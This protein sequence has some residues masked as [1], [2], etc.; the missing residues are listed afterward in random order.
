MKQEWLKGWFV[1]ALSSALLFGCVAD[2]SSSSDPDQGA[3]QDGGLITDSGPG[4]AGGEGGTGG[5]GGAGGAGGA[6][7]MGGE[8]GMGGMGGEGGMG[9]QG[10]VGGAP[11]AAC[12]DGVDND[13]D[14][15]TD[16]PDDPGCT[17]AADDDETDPAMA[18]QCAD[19]LDNDA[20][21]A[22]DL[23]DSDCVNSIDPTEDGQNPIAACSNRLDDDGDGATDFPLDPGC[24]AAGDDDETDPPAPRACANGADDDEDGLIDYPNDPGCQGRGDS[25]ETD[26]AVLPACGNGLDDDGDGAIDYPADEGCNSAADSAEVSSCAA[27]IEVIDLNAHLADN[28]AWEGSLEGGSALLQGSCGGSAGA[29]RVFAYRVTSALRRVTFRT[30]F[31]ETVVPTVV[32]V[33]S[34]CESADDLVC[35][36]GAGDV[37]GTVAGIDEPTQGLYFVVVDTGSRVVGPGPFRLVVEETP[38][39]HCRDGV[40]NDAD[41]LIDLADP[42]CIE[43]DDEDEADPEIVP[44]CADG[45]DNDQDGQADYPNDP[46]C[47]AAGV[48]RERPLCEL[49]FDSVVEVG[50]DGAQLVVEF[51]DAMSLAEPSCIFQLTGGEYVVQLTLDEPSD[52]ALDLQAD[53]GDVPVPVAMYVRADCANPDSEIACAGQPGTRQ[54]QGLEPGTYFIIV[55]ASGEV[56]AGAA[57][58]LSVAVSSL[59]R[60]CNDGDDNDADGLIDL[61]DPGCEQG[62]DN[63][64]SDPLTPPACAD[65]EDND[66]DGNIDWPADQECR[67][68][69][70]LDERL[71]CEA[72]DDVVAVGMDGGVFN[73]DTSGGVNN[74]SSTCAGSATSPEQA[75]ELTL[76]GPA[77][78][79]AEIIE[80]GYDTGLHMRTVCDAADSQVACDDD[81]G[82]GL[83]SRLSFNRLEAGRYFFFADGFG[84]NNSGPGTIEFTIEALEVAQCTDEADN[85]GDG[86]IDSADPG[87]ETPFDLD[88]TDP[89]EPPAC[90]DMLDNDEDGL[91]DFPNDPGCHAAGGLIETDYC[92]DAFPIIEVGQAGGDFAFRPSDGGNLTQGSCAVGDGLEQVLAI[93]LDDP[94]N[95]DISVATAGGA[96]A[97][98]V[99]YVR[100][101]CDDRASE[102][103]CN[104]GPA[105][106]RALDRGTWF[107]FIERERDEPA[108]A[109]DWVVTVAIESLITQC[110][111]E[112]D[113]DD[114]GLIDFADPGCFDARDTDETDPAVLPECG[115]GIDNDEDGATDY[116]DDADCRSA[117]GITEATRCDDIAA[118]EVNQA[119]GRF[120]VNP[121]RDPAGPY[122]ASC[123]NGD[124]ED[125]VFAV[126]IDEL[127]NLTVTS[128][129]ADGGRFTSILSARTACDDANAE[130]DCE[131]SFGG[132]LRL[133]ELEAGT[134]FILVERD[135]FS[136]DGAFEIDIAIESLIRECNDG[137]DND[138]D[139]LIDLDDPGCERGMDDDET[140]PAEVPECSDGIDND[141]DGDIDYPA[142][143]GCPAAGDNTE[144]LFCEGTDNV[145]EVDQAGG[146]FMVNTAG[147][148]DNYSGAAC[149]GGGR[150]EEQVFQLILD[151]PSAVTAEIVA[152][153]FDTMM[154]ARAGNCDV[155]D[156]L[157]CDDDGGAG[158]LSR[159]SFDQLEPGVYYFYT[160]AFSAGNAGAMS[161]QFTIVGLVTECNDGVDNDD[162]GLIDLADPGCDAGA[163]L[164]EADPVE[165][166]ACGD[167]ADN[168]GDGLID[169][170]EDTDCTAAGWPSEAPYCAGLPG[171]LPV[172]GADPLPLDP[173]EAG[174]D[175]YEGSCGNGAG[176]ESIA[177]LTLDVQS[178]VT[179]QVLG[180]DGAPDSAVVSV[181]SVCDAEGSEI[182]CKSSFSASLTEVME[183]GTYYVIVDTTAAIVDPV[184]LV[185][186]VRPLIVACND[187]VDNDD[188]GLIDLADP[189]CVFDLDADETDPADP[190][191]CADGIDNDE[192]GAIDYGEDPECYAAG[193]TSE[194]AACGAVEAVTL[195]EIG[196]DP[197][198]IDPNVAGGDAYEHS[199][200][201]GTNGEAVVGL[202][203][204]ER[205]RFTVSVID[206][207]GEPASAVV[208]VRQACDVAETELACKASFT[209]S[210]TVG[211]AE[212]GLYYI[213]IDADDLVPAGDLTV[214]IEVTSLIVACNDEIDNDEDGLIDLAD[215]GCAG[216]FGDSEIDPDVLPACAD[217]IDNDDDGQI[218]FPDD[219]ACIA[220]GWDF[221]QQLC[222][223]KPVAGALIDA[224]GQFALDTTGSE[225][226]YE[227]SCG[228]TSRSGDQVVFLQLTAPALVT[229][230]TT[231]STFDTT[232]Y[233]RSACDDAATEIAC[234]DDGGEGSQSLLS[235]QLE[236]GDYFIFVDG[237][238]AGNVGQTVLVVDVQPVPPPAP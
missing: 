156:F 203:L 210:L 23:A 8:G 89:A 73:Y 38:A 100:A 82:A 181:R 234:N 185:T 147:N 232:L 2:D 136:P 192:D 45:I 32:Y 87:C 206:V 67:A 208:S 153:D 155:G 119:G 194:L 60:Q 46:D 211:D 122:V 171:E 5:D 66:G 142:D 104:A 169:F 31:D 139:A 167:G 223:A 162:D 201:N 95:V 187:G 233:L 1:A 200:D 148:G 126:T 28:D 175:T 15:A 117:G 149:G 199:C 195:Y 80:A 186:T 90:L 61:A 59:V 123:D 235:Q 216:G 101:D 179:F 158:L 134:Y 18:N 237:Y 141:E 37:P 86:L 48:D 19:G 68:A 108:P 124:G 214:T 33:R 71:S 74:F 98:A 146:L 176:G 152:A 217:G 165:A 65:G 160:D 63:N 129:N 34:N 164:S 22:V 204:P 97:P 172:I 224:G 25:D 229:A 92:A 150:S 219:D 75:F 144:R 20:D 115:D 9:G 130:L 3:S 13:M 178:E 151:V 140:D 182:A 191:A 173:D 102:V 128:L 47:T 12:A 183:A 106:A 35:N 225:N 135:L 81:G 94:S 42:G 180:A 56:P 70:D 109:D 50:Q 30:D 190:P 105:R 110:N 51:P 4:G 188:D 168:D 184:D 227:A 62:M 231:Q 16:F 77:R 154:F 41:G 197:L 143:D 64:E 221:E 120:Q 121:E 125:V 11:V 44:E 226:D 26:P 112:I 6:G 209:D 133:T 131:P 228:S 24:G 145:V 159:L 114:D 137:I 79:S 21:G 230:E 202:V 103:A 198:V 36:R 189:G 10:G 78:V 107:V 193:S 55:D 212:A 174:A 220:A 27:G 85:D 157:G 43:P 72:T 99:V 39:P 161:V 222:L 17:D 118:I 40:D 138:E 52:V 207:E 49:A 113:N 57:V 236:A 132:P 88:E 83:L 218:D 205:S 215:P 127:S 14:G 54:L 238:G 177:V 93:T 111:D 196:G 84:A 29:E 69:G 163:D 58:T 96:A 116:P 76:S 91:I 170:P 166:P 213:I 53:A 7:G